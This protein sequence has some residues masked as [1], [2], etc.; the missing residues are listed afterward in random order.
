MN[1]EKIPASKF[2]GNFGKP[3]PIK[4]VTLAAARAGLEHFVLGFKPNEKQAS[5]H[6]QDIG[7]NDAITIFLAGIHQAIALELKNHPEFNDD[8]RKIHKDFLADLQGAAAKANER[9]RTY[10]QLPPVK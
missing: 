7:I 3:D 5:I 9:M 1:K 4:E 6:F 2:F 10:R 8:Y